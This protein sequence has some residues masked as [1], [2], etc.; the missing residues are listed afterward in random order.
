MAEL[1]LAIV[2]LVIVLVEH[3]QTVL[4]K[5]KALTRPKS[6]NEQQLDFYHELHDELCLL[7]LTLNR[8]KVRHHRG[9]SEEESIERALGANAPHFKK[10]LERILSYIA[11]LVS[12]RSLGLTAEDAVRMRY[13]LCDQ[14]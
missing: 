4:R 8:I 7:N 11:N 14:G 1:A 13:P 3:H 9:D 5:G 10:I 12:E 6:K 2:P